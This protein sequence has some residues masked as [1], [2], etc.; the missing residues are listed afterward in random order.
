MS[1]DFRYHIASLAAIFM[2]L[3]LGILIGTEFVGAPAVAR[4]NRL[5]R[6][7]ETNL[8]DLRRETE[9][10]RKNETALHKLLPSL[11]AKHLSGKRA[12][13]VRSGDY[14]DAADQ[15]VSVLRL[16]GASVSSIVLP[17][18]AWHRVIDP[19]AKAEHLAGLLTGG[20]NA[21]ALDSYRQIG[22][23]SGDALEAPIHLVVLVGG[24]QTPSGPA[25]APPVDGLDLARERDSA[26]VKAWQAA[27]CTV[28]GVENLDADI[29]YMRPYQAADIATVDN[30]DRASGQ[31]ALPFALSGE[32]AAYGFKTTSDTALP[33]S[34][35]KSAVS[36]GP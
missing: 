36:T 29:S 4:Q 27:G 25:G 6:R 17:A 1:P 31:I 24:G 15:A 14:S 22:L 9:E 21:P 28:V 16:A 32:K 5:L 8:D 26:L 12:L 2:A 34:L 18:D 19:A 3:G 11:V 13:V 7:M 30:I 23:V 35:D 20:A 10:A 33:A